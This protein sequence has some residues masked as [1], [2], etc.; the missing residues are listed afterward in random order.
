GRY[1]GLDTSGSAFYLAA[2]EGD[3]P[4]A[5]LERLERISLTSKEIID[6]VEE[7]AAISGR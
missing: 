7:V 3:D 2:W 4:E 1:F 5:L 6:V